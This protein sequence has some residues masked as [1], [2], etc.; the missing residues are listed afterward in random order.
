MTKILA[1]KSAEYDVTITWNQCLVYEV[2]DISAVY[3]MSEIFGIA[4]AGIL[5]DIV[6]PYRIEGIPRIFF[7][8][9]FEISTESKIQS[10]AS[11][12]K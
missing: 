1:W 6:C 9:E 2:P 3:R 10:A 8:K 12:K 4:N 5:I 7:T 11:G